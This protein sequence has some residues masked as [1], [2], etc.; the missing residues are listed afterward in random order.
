MAV[1]DYDR[2]NTRSNNIA[3]GELVSYLTKIGCRETRHRGSHKIFQNDAGSI[4]TVPIGGHKPDVPDSLR[5]HTLDF[6]DEHLAAHAPKQKDAPPQ[7][8]IHI[9][10]EGSIEAAGLGVYALSQENRT[11]TLSDEQY[12]E[13]AV[14]IHLHDDLAVTESHIKAAVAERD[15][16]V[17]TYVQQLAHVKTEHHIQRVV[18]NGEAQL[19]IISR[20]S[21]AM[22]KGT[23]PVALPQLDACEDI[24]EMDAARHHAMDTI[25][26]QAALL[27]AREKPT[28]QSLPQRSVEER[29]AEY[30]TMCKEL[31]AVGLDV[32][33]RRLNPTSVAYCV[34]Y[35]TAEG[36][37]HEF[38]KIAER[39]FAKYVNHTTREIFKTYAKYGVNI[40]RD[41]GVVKERLSAGE[42]M[43]F[44]TV[45]HND[46]GAPSEEA[47]IG[48][49]QRVKQY[50][51]SHSAACA[52]IA[53]T[54]YQLSVLDDETGKGYALKPVMHYTIT[55]TD[56]K[57]GILSHTNIRL[58]HITYDNTH[59]DA[60][61]LSSLHMSKLWRF[62]G[63]AAA[64]E[65]L[66]IEAL[67]DIGI[68]PMMR[69]DTGGVHLEFVKKNDKKNEIMRIPVAVTTPDQ[70]A[71]YLDDFA[72]T[73]KQLFA[74]RIPERM[75]HHGWS[76]IGDT[77]NGMVFTC[78]D[79]PDISVTVPHYDPQVLN[80]VDIKHACAQAF[81][82]QELADEGR[83]K[84]E[85]V[86]QG[87]IGI[88]QCNACLEELMA[89]GY[90]VY[91]NGKNKLFAP[92]NIT[93]LNAVTYRT[94]DELK[95]KPNA[96]ASYLK[97]LESELSGAQ[98]KRAEQAG[99]LDVIQQAFGDKMQVD[100]AGITLFVPNKN[101]DDIE[102]SYAFAK[103][104]D[105]KL[106][107]FMD[108][109][110]LRSI[111]ALLSPAESRTRAER[112]AQKSSSGLLR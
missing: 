31:A 103:N 65:E 112:Y 75:A 46:D 77:E 62:A 86:A 96:V 72:D 57:L 90:S 89:L 40:T 51:A 68:Y 58:R 49:K 8:V 3:R 53:K 110:T 63:G 55:A 25:T 22:K 111:E 15:A 107:Q 102:R 47:L 13:I 56:E 54:S 104:R 108:D 66:L 109:A 70:I 5:K 93:G 106:T 83:Q 99:R 14:M 100:T 97:Q 41:I 37:T 78:D 16:L 9:E 67:S 24:A 28:T 84:Q 17:A 10:D 98:K 27:E 88:T 11:V 79:H 82:K 74:V 23:T 64:Y 34:S 29:A 95:A 91:A 92:Q 21:G 52:R 61:V 81:K 1:L 69:T 19:H 39:F 59:M 45:A 85:D 80:Q 36:R 48:I 44:Y 101:G 60:G 18:V 35:G 12:P 33:V 105:G 94:Q 4:M 43:L 20:N 76:Q 26:Q 6:V 73:V 71:D 30:E 32:H 2:L 7:P 38:P 87:D 50:A 42:D